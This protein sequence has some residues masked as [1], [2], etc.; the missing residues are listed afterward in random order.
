VL[1]AKWWGGRCCESLEGEREGRLESERA[2][3]ARRAR[4]RARERDSESESERQ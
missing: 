4:E 1:R 2:T 3:R